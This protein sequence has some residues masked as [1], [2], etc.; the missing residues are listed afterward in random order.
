M[1][2]ERAA[3]MLVMTLE[4]KAM[5]N[6]VMVLETELESLQS[7]VSNLDVG[8]LAMASLLR[9]NLMKQSSDV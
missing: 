9:Q 5:D 1:A 6:L 7:N 2:P 8:Q 4:A 3:K